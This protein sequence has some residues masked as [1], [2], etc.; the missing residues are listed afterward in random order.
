MRVFASDGDLRSGETAPFLLLLIAA[1]VLLG[2]GVVAGELLTR[3]I[4][5]PLLDTAATARR[6]SAGDTTARAPTT[7]PARSPRSGLR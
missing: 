3:R 4:V 5:R 7:G 6:L 2:V 1:V